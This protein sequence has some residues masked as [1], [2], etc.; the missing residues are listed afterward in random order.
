MLELGSGTG[1]VGL[2]A[3]ALGASRVVL[4]DGGPPALLELLAANVD[5]NRPLLPEAACLEV[6]QL[7]WGADADRLPAG[8]FAWVCGSDTTYDEEV[9][10]PQRTLYSTRQAVATRV[11]AVATCAQP[12]TV[13]ASQP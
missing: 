11:S 3:A 12:M 13:H 6:A 4:T 2:Y 10:G 1:A 5:A 8:P 9:R 7:Q